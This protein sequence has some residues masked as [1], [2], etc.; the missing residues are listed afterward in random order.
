MVNLSKWR[1]PAAGFADR[2]NWA[3]V[4]APGIVVN[5][6]GS[7]LGGFYYSPADASTFTDEQ[8]NAISARINEKLASL[9]DG[10]SLYVSA[11]RSP[12]SEYPSP[13]D[14]HFPDPVSRRIDAE[15]REQYLSHGAHFTTSYAMVLEYL[16]P[17]IEQTKLKEL[18]ITGED[19][20]RTTADLL[21]QEFRAQLADFMDRFTDVAIV[22]FMGAYTVRD[23]RGEA[24]ERDAL[25][26]HLSW[27]VTGQKKPVNLSMEM[28]WLDQYLCHD[29]VSGLEPILD[30][31]THLRVVAIMGFPPST[32]P[33]MLNFLDQMPAAYR[34]T[35]RFIYVG[36]EQAKKE[37]SA[38]RRRW[39]QQRRGLADQV[40]NSGG[41]RINQDAELMVADSD[42]ALAAASSMQVSFGW[43]ASVIV[44]SDADP[45]RASNIADQIKT[46]LSNYG[47]PSRRETVNT[48]EAWFGSLPGHSY[49]NV[50]RPLLTT[51]NLADLIPMSASWPGHPVNPCDMYPAGSPPLLFA[52]TMG[53]TPFRFNLH[54]ED[55]G[56]SLVIGPTGTGKSTFLAMLAA[57]FLRYRDARVFSFDLGYSLYVLA[58]ACG[59]AHYE[60]AAED[61]ELSFCPLQSSTPEWAEGWIRGLC[62]LQ[63]G[64]N[65][66]PR[67]N[68]VLH[69]AV[70]AMASNPDKS[71]S[72]LSSLIQDIE[73]R[74]SLA[75]YLTGGGAGHLL[76][77]E[78]DNLELSR[79]TCFEISHL[80]GLSN[81]EI[82]PVLT[83]LFH[84]VESQLDGSPALILLDEA[85]VVLG[86][87]A[88]RDKLVEWLKTLRKA[89]CAVV[90]ATQ[91]LS[92]ASSSGILDVILEST[93][94][95]IFL[96]NT[97]ALSD[98]SRPFY[99]KVGLSQA[100][101]AQ[102]AEATPKREYYAVSREGSRMFDLMLGPAALAFVA[103]SGPQVRAQVR[104]MADQWGELWP[105]KWVDYVYQ[106]VQDT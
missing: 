11:I 71:L 24:I 89:N 6:D 106:N 87:P 21:L 105:Q 73:L 47:F 17:A 70:V 15:R 19:K 76:D 49:C 64:R 4:I 3:T 59:G 29:F 5:K 12:A 26:E 84:R 23:E 103:Q 25:V 62:E 85:W 39:E 50:R 96:P 13:G 61:A 37:L 28:P 82:L 56:H 1:S 99:E 58:K 55:V 66:E 40:L 77:S 35:T 74:E 54:V 97:N 79:F 101:I 31:D 65:L 36:G 93:S 8:R 52:D 16:P 44:V 94:T 75:H 43:Y 32:M 41:G 78:R 48:T 60:I 2:I 102:I 88:F 20:P 7:F 34:W 69:N 22:D 10:W 72:H 14:M 91:S 98:A 18:M 38:Y 67:Q 90:L 86:H 100:Q 42:D 81:L 53:A 83:Y 30:H 68:I 92:D 63:L 95:H 33:H 45:E 57:Q 51:A 9:G 80:W 27:C 46:A 104:E